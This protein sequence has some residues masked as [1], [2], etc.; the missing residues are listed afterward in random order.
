MLRAMRNDFKKYSWTLWLVIIAFV[1]GFLLTDAFSGKSI[2]KSGLIYVDDEMMVRGEE[3]QR[4]L[5]RTLENYKNQF[6][7]NFNRNLINQF[8]IPEQILQSLYSTALIRTEAEHLNLSASDKEVKQKII[9]YPAFQKD[10]KFVGIANYKRMLA[11]ARMEVADFE[12]QLRDEIIREKFQSLITGALVMD[13]DT[14]K[15][16]Y[17]NEKDKA[18]LDYIQLRTERIKDAIEIKDDDPKIKAYYDTHKEEFKSKEKRGGYVIAYKFDDFKKDVTVDLMEQR[19][20]FRQNQTDYVIPGKTKISRILLNYTADNRED[21]YKKITALKAELTAANFA[22]KAKAM[23]QDNRAPQGGDHGYEGWKRFTPQEN[24]F[25]K[26]LK[27][28]EISSP[29]DTQT[30]FSIVFC[31]EKIDAKKQNFD[32]VKDKIKDTLETEKVNALVQEKLQKIYED[33]KDAKDLKAKAQKMKVTVIDTG[34]LTSGAPIKD[35]DEMGYISRN[36]FSLKEK[37]IRFPVQFA[38]GIAI[39][40]LTQIEEPVV[41][42]FETVK[43]Q[44]KAKVV[45]NVKLDMLEADAKKF[46]AQLN[47]LTDEKEKE[48]YLKKNNLNKDF[49]TYKTGNKFGNFPAQEGMDDIIFGAVEKQFSTPIKFDNAVVIYYVKNKTITTDADFAKDKSEFY[50]QKV[51]E[52]KNSYFSSYMANRMKNYKVTINQKLYTEIKDQILA[53]YNN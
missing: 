2:E 21:V 44:V 8:R 47:A 13:D 28:G 1:G 41:E 27:Q 9:T 18:E 24:T 17:K 4:Q 29:I 32:D 19:N 26:E 6:K 20:Y 25:I 23:S 14:L 38:K 46:A 31:P 50:Q 22:E 16:K 37:D 34:M 39:V 52:I 48:D 49:V 36:L 45:T 12:E 10:G 7:N 35:V 43:A 33:V 5:M 3:Y 53:R 15:E 51:D 11:Y 30:G 40:Q 42:A